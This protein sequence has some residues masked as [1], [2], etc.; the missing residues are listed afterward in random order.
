LRQ[1]GA[2]RASKRA[3]PTRYQKW[4]IGLALLLLA[5]GLGNLARAAMALRYNLLLPDLPLTTPPVYLAA[6]GGFWGLVFVVCA[7]GLVRLWRWSRWFTLA[8]VTVYEIHVWI[9]RLSFGAND[10]GHLTRP[11]DL[12]L[13]FLLLA[14][15]WGL[16]NW[17]GVGEA[18]KPTAEE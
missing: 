15:V 16:L 2:K 17:P 12:A 9:N 14:L 13:T 3:N 18:F 11:R 10:Y 8:A 1:A 5:L 7:I 4:A 6:M